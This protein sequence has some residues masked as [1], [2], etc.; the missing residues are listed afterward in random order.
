VPH[1]RHPAVSGAGP[2]RLAPCAPAIL[3]VV[4]VVAV[5]LLRSG[6]LLGYSN[7]IVDEERIVATAL[8]FIDFDLNPRWFNYHPLPMEILGA[9]YYGMYLVARGLGWVAS[10]PAF[11]AL[12]FT[13]D[14]VFY[15]PAKLLGSL[16]YTTGCAVLA[17]IAWRETRSRGMAALVFAAPL[18]LPDGI[19]TAA[20]VRNDTF[21]F[22]FLAL[23][24]HF[25]CFAPKRTS[26]AVLAA[27]ACAAAFACKIPAI[28][29][30]PVLLAALAHD[31]WRG[32]YPWRVVGGAAALFPL[33]VFLFMP[34]AL[35]D[36]ATYW[37]TITR[38]VERASG[39]M[40][41][42]GKVAHAGVG[43]KLGALAAALYR[44]TGTVPLAGTVLYAAWAALRERTLAFPLLF[45][46]AYAAAFSTS[47]TL[48]DYWLRPV[49]PFLL[50]FPVLLAGRIA[51]LGPM[52]ALWRRMPPAFRLQNLVGPL[53]APGAVLTVV[54]ALAYAG[55]AAPHLSKAVGLATPPEAPDTRIQAGA[56]IRTH[57]PAGSRIVL[58]GMLA[59][60][61]P[62]VF[63]RDP[64]A[65]LWVTGY[66]WPN[67]MR[68]DLL[69]AGFRHYYAEAA[70][71][72]RPFR[73]LGLLTH[74]LNYDMGRIP[75]QKGDYVVLSSYSYARYGDK[76]LIAAEPEL[77]ANARAFF[78]FVRDQE[79]VRTFTGNGPRIEIWRMRQGLGAGQAAGPGPP[80]V[81]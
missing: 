19:A 34:Y 25:A 47:R 39:E 60:Y 78:A 2:R 81:R 24:V 73:V 40:T 59:H 38:T 67:L 11:A 14:G 26:S 56:W 53:A 30:L 64:E 57:L 77:T 17:R 36:F 44:N 35:L 8:G 21:V 33:A 74:T 70:R 55:I 51:A 54:L 80:P 15:V 45:V 37:P 6:S 41:H 22:L 1:P 72:E 29:C 10:K 46:L 5:T 16:A 20:Q 27:V 68:N 61:Q 31:A 50:L 71:T 49:Y 66:R 4:G 69:M 58:E 43:D 42:L 13:H 75:L 32:R 52:A 76:A 23:T 79:A 18:L 63:T 9:L 62:R 7:W 65:L 28:V 48:D 3:A 12:L